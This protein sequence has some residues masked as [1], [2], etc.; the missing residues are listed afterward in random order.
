MLNETLQKCV[1]GNPNGFWIS[2]QPPLGWKDGENYV[3][4]QMWTCGVCGLVIALP[5]GQE[6]PTRRSKQSKD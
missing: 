4:R 5:Y 3:Q 1:E 6:V 2:V